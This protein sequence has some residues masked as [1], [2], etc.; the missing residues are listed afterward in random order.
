MKQKNLQKPLKK[1]SCNYFL[2]SSFVNYINKYYPQL[3]DKISNTVSPMIA[4]SRLIKHIDPK[5]RIVLLAL[6]CKKAEAME[7]ELKMI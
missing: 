7:E 2:L 6:Y 5:A 3:A 1:G 4:I